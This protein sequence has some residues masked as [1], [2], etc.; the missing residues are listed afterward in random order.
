MTDT[1]YYIQGT[2]LVK[3]STLPAHIRVWYKTEN[4]L[5]MSK[6]PIV[7]RPKPLVRAIGP[8]EQGIVLCTH[9]KPK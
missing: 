8:V 9:H 6:C 7:R 5:Q 4:A 2:K 3:I 1:S